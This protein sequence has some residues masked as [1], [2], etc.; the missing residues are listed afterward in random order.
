M[1]KTDFLVF[2]QIITRIS[3]PGVIANCNEKEGAQLYHWSGIDVNELPMHPYRYD[4][5][6][7][8]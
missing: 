3:D 6:R 8:T 7:D 4:K 1:A 5:W 2:N